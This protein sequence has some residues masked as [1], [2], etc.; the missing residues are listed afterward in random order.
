MS[1]VALWEFAVNECTVEDGWSACRETLEE[2]EV[3]GDGVNGGVC[4]SLSSHSGS[5]CVW[6]SP[7]LVVVV[8][9]YYATMHAWSSSHRGT[10]HRC[11]HHAGAW[12]PCGR[13]LA[14]ARGLHCHCGMG[15]LCP[16][17]CPRA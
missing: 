1:S 14:G 5:G 17:F 3:S 16:C 9:R 2:T 6:P 13:R 11:R 10:E 4:K 12:V 7:H 8:Q 15:A